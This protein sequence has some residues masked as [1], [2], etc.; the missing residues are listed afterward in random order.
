[1]TALA[2]RLAPRLL[3]LILTGCVPAYGPAPPD[4]ALHDARTGWR[5]GCS[6]C[7]AV[8]ALGVLLKAGA[9]LIVVLLWKGSR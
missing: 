3:F 6:H 8:A 4:G 5:A 7:W 2:L 1:M 9:V